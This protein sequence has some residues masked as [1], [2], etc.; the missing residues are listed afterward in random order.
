[1]DWSKFAFEMPSQV[2]LIQAG[3]A[4]ALSAAAILFSR[5]MS[6]RWADRASA[7]WLGHAGGHGEGLRGRIL[8]LLRHGVAAAL[9]TI[10]F[11]VDSWSG[12]ARF[13]I[14]VALALQAAWFG[15]HL[16]RGLGVGRGISNGFALAIF[17]ALFAVALGGFD[18]MT[19]SMEQIGFTLGSRRW[20]LLSVAIFLLTAIALYAGVRLANRLL[21]HSIG[22]SK[23]L[24]PTQKV[25][26]QKLVSIGIVIAA[27]LLAIDI[28]NIDLTS[29][30][31]FSG[32]LGLAVGFGLQKTFG[33]LIAGI[34]L[35]M[36]RSIKPGD[37]IAVGDS[38]GEVNRIGIRA[39][40]VIT[41]E[42]KE[43]LIPNEN[44]MTQ[45]VE[46]WS[47]TNRNVRVGIPVSVAYSTDMDRARE[48]MLQAVKES[49]RV[50]NSPAAN[51]L[52]REWADSAVKFE[53]RCWIN[54]PEGGLS[55]VRSDV[56]WRLWNLFKEEGIEIPF[57]QRD[58]HVRSLPET[59]SKSLKK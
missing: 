11:V 33:N 46:N 41:R 1:M 52:M 36:D 19:A 32:A 14:G 42:G 24:D 5:W 48:L 54:D 29:L 4:F 8:A 27:C 21:A 38:F 44:L 30:A 50:L 31:V 2:A 17:A 55:N 13:I 34:I 45:E 43:H 10:I 35:L 59:K 26:G 37:V 28:F 40:S 16:L 3:I 6:V 49:P 39:M 57:P 9:L 23:G 22:A 25:L 7:W 51:I 18:Q 12:L 20:S 53:I 15:K 47:Y 58:V 56:L